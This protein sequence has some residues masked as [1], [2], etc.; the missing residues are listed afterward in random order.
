M[1]T[2]TSGEA[3]D[4]ASVR[5]VIF[6]FDGVMTDN[7][8]TVGDDGTEYVRCWRGDGFGLASLERIGVETIVLSTETN[9]VVT[10]RCT[11]LGV[12]CAQGIADKRTHLEELLADRGIDPV[13]AAY[14]GNDI[15]DL[16]CLELVGL[17]IVV[18]DAHNAVRGAALYTTAAAGGYGAVREVCDR[19]VAAREHHGAL[20]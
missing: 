8:V 10:V 7:T 11:K 3:P 6:D 5:I 16:G 13:E 14:V 17:P 1:T 4:W 12:E 20:A 2:G 18:A 15:N 19:I 9:P